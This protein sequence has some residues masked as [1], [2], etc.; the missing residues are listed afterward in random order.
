MMADSSHDND[1][2]DFDSGGDFDGGGGF[3]GGDF[4]G[5]DF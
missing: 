5:G 1:G 2:G 3:D 4:G